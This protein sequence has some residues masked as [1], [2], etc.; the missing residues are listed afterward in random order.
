[1]NEQLETCRRLSQGRGFVSAEHLRNA[2]AHIDEQAARIADLEQKLKEAPAIQ[3]V[4]DAVIAITSN[5]LDPH[6]TTAAMQRWRIRAQDF[7]DNLNSKQPA[8]AMPLSRALSD[9]AAERRRQIEVEGWTPEHDDQYDN[10][11]LAY[12]AGCYAMYTMARPEGPIPVWPWAASW[13][14]PSADP[15]RNWIKA[16]ALIVA[17]IERF[18]RAALA[19]HKAQEV[20]R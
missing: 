11:I 14:K 1:M 8:E 15:R 9:I 20:E 16:G 4:C 6:G 5:A 13:W 10:H 17:E 2:V 3:L 12:A 19:A 18:D 7:L